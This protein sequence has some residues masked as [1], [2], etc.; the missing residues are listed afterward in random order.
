L[1][2]PAFRAI[3]PY[4][5]I[6]N[7]HYSNHSYKSLYHVHKKYLTFLSHL[8][9]PIEEILIISFTS[10]RGVKVVFKSSAPLSKF[11]NTTYKIYGCPGIKLIKSFD[12]TWAFTGLSAASATPEDLAQVIS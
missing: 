9:I 3:D 10:S 11:S 4:Y 1:L 6:F 2:P 5:A 12:P 8:G 7:T